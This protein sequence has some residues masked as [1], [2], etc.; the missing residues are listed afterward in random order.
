MR[1]SVWCWA[2]SG[3]RQR[4]RTSYMLK[5]GSMTRPVVGQR[6]ELCEE[7]CAGVSPTA[8]SANITDR[9]PNSV[10]KRFMGVS[11][12]CSL[13]RFDGGDPA[14]HLVA[15][16]GQ[17]HGPLPQHRVVKCPQVEPGAEAP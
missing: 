1:R 9:L 11:L 2:E 10:S 4:P 12:V 17:A 8:A 7:A 5:P 16:C 14:G 15:E 3:S 13:L 6:N